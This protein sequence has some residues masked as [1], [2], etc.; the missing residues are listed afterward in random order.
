ME[1]ESN[2]DVGHLLAQSCNTYRIGLLGSQKVDAYLQRRRCLL[3]PAKHG[4]LDTP[5]LPLSLQER[6]SI[7]VQTKAFSTT[8]SLV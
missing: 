7:A 5:L 6:R 1:P 2:D 8:G 4:N 3:R